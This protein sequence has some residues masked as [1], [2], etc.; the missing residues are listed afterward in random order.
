MAGL[1]DILGAFKA[2]KEIADPAKWKNVGNLT[3]SLFIVL[4]AG[5]TLYRIFIGELPIADEDLIKISGACA[6]VIMTLR[7]ILTV[8]T[9]KKDVSVTGVVKPILEEGK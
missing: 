5:V 2:G 4:S 6:T 3:G 8:V 9:T 7:N 1:L